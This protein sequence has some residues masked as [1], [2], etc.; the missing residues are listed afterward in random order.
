MNPTSVEVFNL[1]MVSFDKVLVIK[2]PA[3][4]F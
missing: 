2:S 1:L 4:V 3:K